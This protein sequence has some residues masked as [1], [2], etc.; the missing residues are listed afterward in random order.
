MYQPSVPGT[1]LINSTTGSGTVT[2]PAVNWYSYNGM[3]ATSGDI[4]DDD[5]GNAGTHI[6]MNNGA[7]TLSQCAA[8][9]SASGTAGHGSSSV[10][11]SSSIP[12][13]IVRLIICVVIG[14]IICFLLGVFVG[15]FVGIFVGVIICVFVCVIIC[16]IIAALVISILISTVIVAAGIIITNITIII[17]GISSGVIIRRDWLFVEFV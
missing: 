10:S 6:A 7:L 17:I 2:V 16:I 4:T 15:V 12:P 9:T 5:T 1:I 14:F 8:V 11:V 3:A 13:V